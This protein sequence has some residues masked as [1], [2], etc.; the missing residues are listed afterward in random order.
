LV[1]LGAILTTAATNSDMIFAGRFFIGMAV[2]SLSTA[3]PM[4][5]SE[6]SPAEVRGTMVGTWQ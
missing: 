2:G 5:N 1:I 4:Y 3:V 6:V